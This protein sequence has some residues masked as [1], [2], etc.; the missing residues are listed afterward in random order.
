MQA[1]TYCIYLQASTLEI[2]DVVRLS[3]DHKRS[4]LIKKLFIK[5]SPQNYLFLKN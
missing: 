1:A 2:I 4:N 5:N 3:D